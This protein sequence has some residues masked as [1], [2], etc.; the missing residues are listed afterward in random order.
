MTINHKFITG[1]ISGDLEKAFDSVDQ[2]ILLSKLE[3]Y[4]VTGKAK[5]WFESYFNNR[6]QTVLIKKNN[7]QR[8]PS[9][10]EKINYGVPQ[11]SMF[12]QLLF[13]LYINDLLRTIYNSAI[14]ILFADDTSIMIADP[15]VDNF[16]SR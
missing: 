8:I 14:P 13:Q 16:Q 9:I 12:S 11:G 5:L 3:F 2:E 15:N 6:H 1:G 7:N 4:R 10:W